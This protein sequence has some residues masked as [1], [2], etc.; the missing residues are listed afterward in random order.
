M[1]SRYLALGAVAIG[2][3]LVGSA[4]PA[5]ADIPGSSGCEGSG[6]WLEDG[7]F[8]QA[9]TAGGVYEIPRSDTVEW[10]GSVAGPPGVYSGSVAIDMPPGF[11]DITVDDWGGDSESTG[12]FGAHEY[13]LPSVIP[14]GVEFDVVGVHVDENGGCS[15]TITF[16]IAGGAFD[17]PV[18][19]IS[20]GATALFAIGTA[21]ALK[22]AFKKVA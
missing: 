8:V 5:H 21:F 16:K 1:R 17:S 2:F 7:L 10:E 9:E 12:N 4:S 18:T 19:L 3:V 14:A 11:P 20:L 15:G 22:P 13:D 6:L